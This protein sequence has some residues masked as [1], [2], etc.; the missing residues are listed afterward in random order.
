MGE[1]GEGKSW[2]RELEERRGSGRVSE[3]RM[4]MRMGVWEYEVELKE[5]TKFWLG[6]EE[7]KLKTK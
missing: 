7:M 6:A 5:W 1:E 4:S 2:M 3:E